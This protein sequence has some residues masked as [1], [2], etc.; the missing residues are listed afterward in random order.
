MVQKA[1]QESRI[2]GRRFFVEFTSRCA[3]PGW[4]SGVV[5]KRLLYGMLQF[6]L[7]GLARR[8]CNPAEN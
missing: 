2:V 7:A 1:K 4:A 3:I 5:G 6:R 8:Q